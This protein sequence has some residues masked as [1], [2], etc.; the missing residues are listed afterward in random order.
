MTLIDP[1][2]R[3]IG[4]QLRYCRGCGCDDD[5]ACVG[6]CAWV[7]VDVGRPTG[8]CSTC[9]DYAEWHPV[10]LAASG[11]IPMPEGPLVEMLFQWHGPPQGMLA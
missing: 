3:P 10:A 8:I 5:H 11:D 4:R 7:L 2:G 9:A 1:Q 6:G